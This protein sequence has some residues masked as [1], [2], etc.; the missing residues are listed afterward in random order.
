M[1]IKIDRQLTPCIGICSTALGD[2]IC[3][4]CNRTAKQVDEWRT[5]SDNK[6]RE[7]MRGIRDE[8]D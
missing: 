5:Y 2:K 4:G 6:K 8:R 3:R 1:T 7:I